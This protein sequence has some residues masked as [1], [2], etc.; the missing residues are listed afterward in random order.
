MYKCFV[1]VANTKL[2]QANNCASKRIN[3]RLL[4][5]LDLS[6]ITANPSPP[7]NDLPSIP[8]SPVY[9]LISV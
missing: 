5:P 9:S 4:K 2:L 8:F 7:R 6:V 1:C 3:I